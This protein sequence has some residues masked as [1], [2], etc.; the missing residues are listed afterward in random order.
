MSYSESSTVT[1]GLLAFLLVSI[2]YLSF[3]ILKP[4]FVSLA[5][6]G[7]LVLVTWPIYQK[8]HKRLYYRANLSAFVMTAMLTLLLLGPLTWV[9]FLLQQE[10]RTVYGLASEL[11]A[12]P[13]LPL[14]PVVGEYLPEIYAMADAWWK[15]SHADPQSSQENMRSLA[16][17]GIPQLKLILAE[18]TRNS[19]KLS[20][21]VFIAF[22]F[23]RNGLLITKQL[24]LALAVITPGHGERYI[25]AAADMTQAVVFGIVLTAAAQSALAG[26][27][28]FVADVPNPTFLMLIT[29]LIALIP[30]GTPF[31][32]GSVALWLLL[33]GQ[34]GEA[35]GLVLWGTFVISW[36]DNI[37]RPLVISTA[38]K[39]SFLVI[40][41]GVLGGLSA[42]GMVGLFIGPV[43][44]A[45]ITA[46][47][48]EWITAAEQSRNPSS[49]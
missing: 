9:L 45:V 37:I 47:W 32:W 34:T 49:L 21:T 16:S 27:A 42:F 31:A 3:T 8:V 23:Y 38:S 28:Y 43:I 5:W 30:F 36:V 12:S 1:K 2:G 46:M 22:F 39:V 4:F 44:L 20:M 24:R 6:A 11:I 13:E 41:L 18:I 29:F 19:I 10:L 7:I 25:R 40:M 48:S 35:L 15:S 26:A 17:L 33:N 14:P